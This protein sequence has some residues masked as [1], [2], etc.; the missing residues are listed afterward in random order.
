[1]WI[2]DTWQNQLK[3][4]SSPTSTKETHSIIKWFNI[5]HCLSPDSHPIPYLTT[6]PLSTALAAN[7]YSY[8]WQLQTVS[9]SENIWWGY[10][11]FH[12]FDNTYCSVKRGTRTVLFLIWW[13]PSL[14]V[15]SDTLMAF[16]KSCLLQNT[17][18]TA[19]LSSSSWSWLEGEWGK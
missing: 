10:P 19:S 8:Q 5:W 2:V 17:N 16:G 15:T 1:M 7:I 11:W 3:T 6:V 18:T 12:R 13:S 9:T 14:S 4:A